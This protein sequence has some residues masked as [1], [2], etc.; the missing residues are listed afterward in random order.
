MESS[1]Q[2]LACVPR[3]GQLLPEATELSCVSLWQYIYQP[4]SEFRNISMTPVQEVIDLLSF[5][6]S[7]VMTF[8]QCF[9]GGFGHWSKARK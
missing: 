4:R 8:T 9:I 6:K 7:C 2:V 5:W 3:R 1:P